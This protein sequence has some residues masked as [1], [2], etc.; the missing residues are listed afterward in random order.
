MSD[1]DPTEKLSQL[2][3]EFHFDLLARIIPGILF[4]W[5]YTTVP[6][7][8][9]REDKEVITVFAWLISAYFAGLLM[10]VLGSAITS[11]LKYFWIDLDLWLGQTWSDQAVWEKLDGRSSIPRIVYLKIL[12]ERC[13]FRS[14]FIIGLITLIGS[15]YNQSFPAGDLPILGTNLPNGLVK[16]LMAIGLIISGFVGY[17]R[18]TEIIRER[19]DFRLI[20][21][22][23][24][25]PLPDRL[26]RVIEK[27]MTK[28]GRNFRDASSEPAPHEPPPGGAAY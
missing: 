21:W 15:I 11:F 4:C 14:L 6:P 26:K 9:G 17:V 3:P 8:S 16:W 28:R 20:R 22:W 13:L 12:A 27:L 18:M 23:E 1:H 25:Y 24:R 19:M 2:V 10:D 5:L 7:L